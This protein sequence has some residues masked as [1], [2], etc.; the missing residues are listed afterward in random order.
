MSHQFMYWFTRLD[1][2][3][4]FFC[5]A[6]GVNVL[7]LIFAI[8]I[9]VAESG[10]DAVKK[11]IKIPAVTLVIFSL[12]AVLT[13]T[14]KEAAAIYFIPKIVNNERLQGLANGSLDMMEKLLQEY[15]A[16]IKTGQETK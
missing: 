16:D 3:Q 4:F 9:G 15:L 8:I 12:L 7:A 6:A 5:V 14:Q 11:Y 2:I 1:N 10:V 13:P